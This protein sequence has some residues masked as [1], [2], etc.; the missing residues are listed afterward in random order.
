MRLRAQDLAGTSER[1]TTSVLVESDL[2]IR[3]HVAPPALGAPLHL[4]TQLLHRGDLIEKDAEVRLTIT[5]PTVSL[6]AVSTPA[7]VAAALNAD[8]API[9]AGEGS[10][11]ATTT[12]QF[13]LDFNKRRKGYTTQLPVPE[14]DGVYTFEVEARGKQCSGTFERYETFSLYIGRRPHGRQSKVSI[15]SVRGNL[16]NIVIDLRDLSG[17]PLGPGNAGFFVAS[18]KGGTVWPVVDQGDGTYVLR[19]TWSPR[20]RKP[21]LRIAIG[22]VKWK[23]PLP[24]AKHSPH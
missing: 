19:A 24:T 12:D 8:R 14:V 17:E 16:A 13:M 20:L 9:P 23:L 2:K 7:V 22:D 6:A 11:I 21:V 5:S 3:S 10:L 4:V 18:L 15:Q 1:C